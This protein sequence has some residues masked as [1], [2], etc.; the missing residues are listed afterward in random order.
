MP[1]IAAMSP[2]PRPLPAPPAAAVPARRPAWPLWLVVGVAGWAGVAALGV[3]LYSLVPRRAGFDLELLLGAGRRVAGGETP[4]DAGMLAGRAPSA[5][6]LFYS[7]PP[8]VAQY[9]SLFAAIPSPV[10][11][12]AWGIAAGV[13]LLAVA[14]A[15]AGL[16][17]RTPTPGLRE[18]LRLVGLPVVAIAPFVFPFA[19]AGLFGNLDALFP[20]LYGLM[21]VGALGA[22]PAS[23]FAGGAALAMAAVAKLHPASMVIWFLVRGLRDRRRTPRGVRGSGRPAPASGVPGPLIVAASAAAVGLAILVVSL[24][25]GGVT[26]WLDY[27]AVLRAGS[28]AE[29]VDARNIGPAAQLALLVGGGESLG[30]LAQIV[31]LLVAVAGTAAAAW[32]RDDTVESFAWATVASLVILPVT[33]FHYPVALLP[34]AV[35]VWLRADGPGRRRVLGLFAAAM[36]VGVLAVGVPVLIWVSVAL[37]LLAARLTAPAVITELP[38]PRLEP[39]RISRFPAPGSD[40]R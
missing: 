6:D 9:L 38:F 4:Y 33:W 14:V 24:I 15:L 31:V 40:V 18:H 1:T 30:R 27:A 12:V 34:V 17:A 21:L 39:S 28:A 11:L 3:Q 5:V 23:R 13:G 2:S 35:A 36:V 32:G 26:P 7:Y 37:V 20:L 8:P 29:V 25:A 22:S 16:R 19:I 10:M